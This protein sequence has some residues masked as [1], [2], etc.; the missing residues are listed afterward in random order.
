MTKPAPRPSSR[1]QIRW[2][3]ILQLVQGGL[4][5]GLPFLA[6]PILLAFGVDGSML[7]R[8][9][10]FIVPFFDDNLFLMMALSGVFAA[11]RIIGAV[12][13]FKDRMW[14]YMLSMINCVVTLAL[15][16]FMLPAGIADG[17]LSGAAL[18]LL[19]LARYGDAPL[20]GQNP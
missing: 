1:R 7:A 16:I 9:F 15:M 5:E 13:L 19:L 11:L 12:G 18:I 3:A 8:G 14:G 4:L 20:L 6:L 2:A 17:V 10:S